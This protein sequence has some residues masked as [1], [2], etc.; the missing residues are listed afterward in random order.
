M[1]HARFPTEQSTPVACPR[2]PS[3]QQRSRA[4]QSARENRAAPFATAHRCTRRGTL[5]S[6]YTEFAC[7]VVA[8]RRSP[9]DGGSTLRA[10]RIGLPTECTPRIDAHGASSIQKRHGCRAKWPSGW[11]ELC[12]WL[13]KLSQVIITVIGPWVKRTCGKLGIS[14]TRRQS[15]KPLG[16]IL[17]PWNSGEPHRVL[18]RIIVR[19]AGSPFC[20]T[21]MAGLV[22]YELCH[23]VCDPSHSRLC[24]L[25]DGGKPDCGR[26]LSEAGGRPAAASRRMPA[27]VLL[28]HVRR[29]V[30]RDGMLQAT[31][32]ARP[33]DC[34][35]HSDGERTQ[36]ANLV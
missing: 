11:R 31:T 19:W 9:D 22:V 17:T 24:S 2:R 7:R 28:R 12:A 4:A 34:P 33:A 26:V 25:S 27:K 6:T 13:N 1:G 20:S 3:G 18:S 29:E 23:E 30:L 10:A 36:V 32:R 14:G 8:S 15:E 5:E 16:G 35:A 21:L